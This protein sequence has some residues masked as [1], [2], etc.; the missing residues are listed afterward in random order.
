MN[1][2]LKTHIRQSGGRLTKQRQL[3]LDY[4][5]S[6]TTHP[7]AEVIY[8][9]VRKKISNISLGTVY[10]NLKYLA[11]R[12]FI[13]QLV[14]GEYSRFDGNTTYHLHFICQHC[15]KIDDIFDTPD[16]FLSKIGD[17]GEI[18]RI[19]CA[20]YG[21][22]KKCGQAKLFKKISVPASRLIG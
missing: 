19:E 11:E 20:V 18:D 7:N 22:C 13:L 8:K 21:V 12:G 2:D 14:Q 15:G 6:V 4:L 16:I 1:N 5:Q 9:E 17:V 3:I 10:R